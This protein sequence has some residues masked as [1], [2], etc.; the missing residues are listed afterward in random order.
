LTNPPFTHRHIALLEAFNKKVRDIEDP[1]APIITN[2][3]CEWTEVTLKGVGTIPKP[4]LSPNPQQIKAEIM[5]VA[6]LDHIVSEAGRE[7]RHKSRQKT[8]YTP[9]HKLLDV[10]RLAQNF[11]KIWQEIAVKIKST[12]HGPAYVNHLFIK[13]GE[14]IS[15]PLTILQ[16]AIMTENASTFKLTEVELQR[17]QDANQGQSQRTEQLAS[18]YEKELDEVE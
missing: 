16:E 14:Q 17:A 6:G 13:P 9:Q 5:R 18:S 15:Q 12:L 8:G 2:Q 4:K 1:D 11:D 10:S 7:K 3:S